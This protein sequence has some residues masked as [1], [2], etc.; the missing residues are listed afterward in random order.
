MMKRFSPRWL[1][2]GW[3]LAVCGLVAWSVAANAAVSTSAFLFIVGA[4]P[5]V[6]TTLIG[7]GGPSPTVAEI[8]H[9]VHSEPRRG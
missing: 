4:A 2:T 5:A 6:V 7:L 3:L 8:L 1:L 9:A